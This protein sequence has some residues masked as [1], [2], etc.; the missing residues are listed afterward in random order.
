MGR[1]ATFLSAFR[2]RS[3]EDGNEIEL[4]IADR[5]A[6]LK[7]YGD[8]RLLVETMAEKEF[9]KI[10]KERLTGIRAKV[11]TDSS[12]GSSTSKSTKGKALQHQEKDDGERDR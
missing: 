5:E 11:K 1:I 10:S 4:I 3:D 7:K 2:T 6:I 8:K 9:E 12:G